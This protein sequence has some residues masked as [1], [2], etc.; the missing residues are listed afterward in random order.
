MIR[1]LDAPLKGMR[2]VATRSRKNQ[3]TLRMQLY[4]QMVEPKMGK[5]AK[6]KTCKR[7]LGLRLMKDPEKMLLSHK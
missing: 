1:S 2:K 5:E 7:A 6:T 4:L 3:A